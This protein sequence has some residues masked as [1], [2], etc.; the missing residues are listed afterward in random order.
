MKNIFLCLT[1]ANATLKTGGGSS[2]IFKHFWQ[3]AACLLLAFVVGIGNVWGDNVQE[4]HNGSAAGDLYLTRIQATSGSMTFHSNSSAFYIATNSTATFTVSSTEGSK[5]SNI[6]FTA[7]NSYPINQLTSSD[8]DFSI[9]SNVYTFTP[10]ALKDSYSFTIKSNTSGNNCRVTSVLV[11]LTSDGE[12][13]TRNFSYTGSSNPYTINSTKSNASTDISIK[14]NNNS[15]LISS[16]NIQ[17]GNGKQL[18]IASSGHNIKKINFVC[19]LYGTMSNL[20][21]STGTYNSNVWTA[22]DDTKTVTFTSSG[23][24]ANIVA[25][26][27]DLESGSGSGGTTYDVTYN[28]NSGGVGTTAAQEDNANGASVTTRANGFTPN[29]GKKFKWWNTSADGGGTDYYPGEGLTISGADVELFAQW[30]TVAANEEF[31]VGDPT[32]WTSSKFSVGDMD[33]KTNSTS[34]ATFITDLTS[35]DSKVNSTDKHA[36]VILVADNNNYIQISFSD[37][38]TINELRLGITTTETS[39]KNAAVVYSTTEDFSS[40]EYETKTVS[41]PANN[42]SAK[43]LTNFSPATAN[44]YKYVRIYR[45]L[46][47]QVYSFTGGSGNNLRIYAIKAQKGSSCSAPAAPTI[48]SKNSK[49]AFYVGDAIELTASCASGTDASTTYAWYK[50]DTWAGATKVQN[51]A[52]AANNGNKFTGTAALDDAGTYWCLAANSTCTSHNETG[53]EISVAAAPVANPTISSAVN[54]AGWGSVSDGNEGTSITVTSGSTISISSNVLTCDAKTLTATPAAA[55]AEYTYAFDSW[56]G[57]TNGQSVTMNVTATANFTRTAINYT[58]AWNKNA[59]DA[60]ALAGEFTSGTVAFGTAITKPNTPTREGYKFAGWAETSSGDVVEVPT[61]MPAANK[62][63]FAKWNEIVCIGN[64][65][66]TLFSMAMNQVTDGTKK[67]LTTSEEVN[68]GDSYATVT[69]GIATFTNTGTAK[70]KIDKANPG[71][72]NFDGNAAYLILDLECKLNIGDSIII[73][74][75]TTNEMSFTTSAEIGTDYH[76]ETVDGKGVFVVPSELKDVKKL[77]CWRATS[78]TGLKFS[79]VEVIRPAKYAMTFDAGDGEGSMASVTCIEKSQVTLP[80][81]TFTAPE[82]KEFDAW[83]VTKTVGGAS[84]TVTDGKFTMPQEAV[85]ATATWKAITPKYGVTYVLNGPTG[86][87]PTEADQAEGDEFTLASKPSWSGHVFQGWKWTDNSSV[88]HV[89]DAEAEF[90]MPAYDVTFTAQWKLE[91]N[92]A[93]GNKIDFV[94]AEVDLSS[95]FTSSSDGE[96]TYALKVASETA[97]I[98]GATF[99]ATAAGEYVVVATQATTSTYVAAEKEATIE[100]LASE[101]EDIFIFKK[102]AG[103]GGDGKCLTA[104]QANTDDGSHQYTSTAYEGFAAMGRA[105]AD[106]TECILTF[107]VKPA[108]SSALGIKSI[109]TYGKF[110]EPLGGQISWDGGTSWEDLAAYTDGKKE[111]DAPGTFPTSFKIKFMGVSKKSGGLWWRNALVTLEKKKAIINT[112]IDLTAVKINNVAISA[113]DLATLKTASAYALD[114]ED[115]YVI[116]PT[117]KFNKQTVITYEDASEVKSNVEIPVVATVN[118]GGKWEAQAEIN[119]IT[120]TVTMAKADAFVVNYYEADGETL[121]GSENVAV[122][123]NPT[124]TGIAPTP[125][126]YKES[127]WTLNSAEVALNTVT[128]DEAGTIINLVA[129]YRT[130]YASSINIEKWV[131]DNRKNNTAFRA[132]LDARHYQYANLNDLDSLTTEKNDGDRNYPFLGQKIKTTGGYISF[133]LKAGSE[134]HVKFG[135]IPA[136]VNLIVN[137]GEPVAK[138]ASFDYTAVGS[139][140]IIKLATTTDGTVVFKQIMIDEAIETV[141]LPAIVTYDAN[142]GSFAKT[143]E[144][145]TGTPLVIGDATP[146]NPTEYEF[147]G[148][149]LGSVEGTKIDAAAYEPTKNVTLVAKYVVKPSPFSLSALTYKIGTGDATAVGYEEGTYTYDV[150][151]PYAP[152]YETITVAYTLA[153]GTSSEKSG[154]VLSVTSVPGA[155]TFTI[156]AANTTE[157][158]YTVNFKKDAKDGLSIIKATISGGDEST[159]FDATGLYAGKGYAKTSSRKLNSDNYVGVQLKAGQSFQAGDKLF[160]VT[161][162]AADRGYIE[163]YREAAGTNLIRA[164]GVRDASAGIELPSE[165]YGLNELYIVRKTSDGDQ[166]WNG[167]VNYVEVTRPMNPVLKSITFDDNKIDVTGTTVAETLPYATDLTAVT[168]EYFWNGAGTAVVT[169]NEGAWAWGKNT[170]VLTDK[171]GD[172]TTYTISL[173]RA[174]RSTDATLSSL[175]VNGNAMELVADKYEYTYEYPYGTDPAT[176]PVVAAEANDAHKHSMD[177]TQAT[178]ATGTAEI[179][180]VAEDETTTLT[181]IVR[182]CISRNQTLVIYDGKESEPMNAIANPGSLE[183]GLE[184]TIKDPNSTSASS[185]DAVVFEGKSYKKYVQLF[186]S[187]TAST[188]R[189]MTITIPENYLAKFRLVGCGNGNSDRSLFISKEIA[190]TRDESIAFVHTTSATITGMTSDYQ[191][192]GTYYLCCDASIRIYE[193]SVTLYPIDYTRNVTDG[194]FGTICLQHGG[195]M[196]G[197]AVYEVAYFN[198]DNKKIYFDEVL[199]GEMVPGMP[200]VFLPDQGNNDQLVV[201]YG[202]NAP[203]AVAGHH[204]GLYGSFTEELLEANTVNYILQSNQY[205]YVN[206]GEVYVGENRAYLK[207]AEIYGYQGEPEPTPAQGRRRVMMDAGAQAPQTPTGLDNVQGDN[208]QSAKVL[209]DGKMYILRGEKM[210]D[211]TGRLVK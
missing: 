61:T 20:S 147:E 60:D 178:N 82:N 92:A 153:D 193:L 36:K 50:G 31:W 206:S 17:L 180:V 175:T 158:T 100:V 173:T 131:L 79:K 161:S 177:I 140:E 185:A 62:T 156:V 34:K 125:I 2:Q 55:S 115:E 3:Y 42:A 137:D 104:V 15:S 59:E 54:E 129:A 139:D 171:D 75:T 16:N 144:K 86:D 201:M 39:N 56:S 51:A 118:A 77:Y 182:F 96:V 109:C 23:S 110:E 189:Y 191:Y 11:T 188:T 49:T 199:S 150:E 200:Y 122:N 32:T 154:A 69:G 113:A 87:A 106:N 80:A 184:W 148:W 22:G 124:G 46:S 132:V 7:N 162:T 66:G 168:A 93:F 152:S 203:A 155:A 196:R 179:V 89:E 207:V 33:V 208:V 78:S 101:V 114:I 73:T 58:L 67:S 111:F 71:L 166:S 117:V 27:V 14:V 83:V 138:S 37:G 133:L 204:N 205:W 88:D 41:V 160:V 76:T 126:D 72:I 211:A 13:F 35:S 47:S 105:E 26:R 209:I 127:Y 84:V 85:K 5:I 44:K 183:P 128:S 52:T 6:V 18:T 38:S 102:D 108:Y 174:E 163:L 21:A 164:L 169:T 187:A 24:N 43:S 65:G 121:I 194:R 151:L 116:A 99:T 202:N 165:A 141:V 97:S 134:L 197:A 81:C 103:Y 90:T 172:A 192:P 57:V 181:Y 94:D 28:A 40:G 107:S 53:F 135:N 146:A 176:V 186:T 45:K 70:G 123:G 198:P 98:S 63:Y 68:L 64:E 136:A 12:Y 95:L 112:A 149:H 9:S 30:E 120:Y 170:Y 159:G 167:T 19:V 190:S 119:D 25:I 1:K 4:T 10:S 145:Y 210:Y 48:S 143:S 91:N 29:S 8:G 74:N 195:I 142:G 157:K 130:A